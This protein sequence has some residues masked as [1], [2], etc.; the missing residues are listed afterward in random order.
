MPDSPWMISIKKAAKNSGRVARVTSRAAMSPNGTTLKPGTGAPKPRWKNAVSVADMPA[1]VRPWKA[2]RA[3]R[4]PA[5][6]VRQRAS[7]MAASTASAPL[8]VNTT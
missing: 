3:A 4:M 2:L 5:R 6:P 1:S 8:L 7:F